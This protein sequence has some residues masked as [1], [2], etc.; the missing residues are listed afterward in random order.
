MTAHRHTG[1]GTTTRRVATAA[2]LGGSGVAVVLVCS[3]GVALAD[4]E[5]NVQRSSEIGIVNAGPSEVRSNDVGLTLAGA[6]ETQAGETNQAWSSIGDER[7]NP[8]AEPGTC[9]DV[10]DPA[11]IATAAVGSGL[12]IP[13]VFTGG[14]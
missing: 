10:W 4:N 3:T 8:F 2:L 9:A 6:A 11:N 12:K 14:C 13:G 7:P 5:Q 1:I